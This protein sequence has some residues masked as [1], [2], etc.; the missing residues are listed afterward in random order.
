MKPRLNYIRNRHIS[1]LTLILAALSFA[2][3]SYAQDAHKGA[4]ISIGAG[5]ITTDIDLDDVD[6][7]GNTA[8]LGEQDVNIALINARLG[9]R[10]NRYLAAEVEGGLGLGGESFSRN[11]PVN[12]TGFGTVPVD[13]DANIDINSYGGVFARA[14]LPINKNLDIFARGGY[15]IASARAEI[16]ATTTLLPGTVISDSISDSVDGFA[17]G[18]GGEYHLGR[19]HAIRLDASAV[20]GDTDIQFFAASY[21]Y[22]F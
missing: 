18:I 16:D 21:S 20:S 12:V 22:K 11:V 7:Q 9:Y 3:N 5:L 14:I 2:Q 13:L 17:F 1:Q 4:Y 15:A 8:Q 6:V 19:N 10:F